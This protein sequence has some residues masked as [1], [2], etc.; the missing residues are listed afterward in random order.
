M[1]LSGGFAGIRYIVRLEC[2]CNPDHL[3]PLAALVQ[4]ELLLDQMALK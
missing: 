1:L 4:L 2:E 3:P